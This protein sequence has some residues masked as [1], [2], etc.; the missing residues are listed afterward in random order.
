[1]L[2]TKNK[3]QSLTTIALF[4]VAPLFL[5]FST[6]RFLGLTTNENGVVS[7]QS[8]LNRILLNTR[9]AQQCM[10]VNQQEHDWKGPL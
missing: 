2:S 1:M 3:N 4:V 10:S 9:G 5:A 6:A 8:F 7:R